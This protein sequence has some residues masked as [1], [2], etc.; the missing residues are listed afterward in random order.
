MAGALVYKELVTFARLPA[1]TVHP[2][3]VL[4][5]GAGVGWGGVEW[6]GGAGARGG[7]KEGNTRRKIPSHVFG[8]KS[9]EDR[10]GK[11]VRKTTSRVLHCKMAWGLG[12]GK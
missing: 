7:K 2:H 5:E 3:S 11:W 12:G 4:L 10:L 6:G 9:E 8:G 1:P